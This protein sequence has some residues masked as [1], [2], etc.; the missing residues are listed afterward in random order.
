MDHPLFVVVADLLDH[1]RA[2]FSPVSTTSYDIAFEKIRNAPLLILDHLDTANATPWAKEKLFQILDHRYLTPLPTVITTVLPIQDIDPNI[3]S[4]LVDFQVCQ[5]A[6]MF[7]VPMYSR[8]PQVS[9]L[10]ERTRKGYPS[11]RGK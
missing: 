3:R 11:R 4:R 10:P 1:L 9:I 8:N 7:Q 2:T 6:Q 5:V